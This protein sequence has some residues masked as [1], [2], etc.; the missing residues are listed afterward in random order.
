MAFTFLSAAVAFSDGHKI[1]W[2]RRRMP[3]M[4][5]ILKP[6][7]MRR[8]GRT[9]TALDNLPC[10]RRPYRAKIEGHEWPPN[11]YRAAQ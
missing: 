1:R 7:D 10:R 3:E 2:F 5:K 6:P 4:A 8:A 11:A 9:P